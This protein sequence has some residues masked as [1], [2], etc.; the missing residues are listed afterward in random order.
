MTE[1]FQVVSWSSTCQYFSIS[2]ANLGPCS[3][4]AVGS[5]LAKSLSQLQDDA[6]VAARSWQDRSK[7]FT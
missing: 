4:D 2:Y 7:P 6:K 5:L 1:E 3:S